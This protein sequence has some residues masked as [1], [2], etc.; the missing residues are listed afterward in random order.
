MLYMV[1]SA[2]LY[3]WYDWA[4]VFL[5]VFTIH[6]QDRDMKKISRNKTKWKKLFKRKGM[7]VS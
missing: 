3:L 7:I 6:T 2:S 4:V 5:T 1:F